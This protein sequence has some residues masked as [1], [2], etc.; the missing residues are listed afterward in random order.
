MKI[1]ELLPMKVSPYT[2]IQISKKRT[3]DIIGDILQL[4][5]NGSNSENS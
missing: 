3:E 5:T 1:N 2:L 4:H